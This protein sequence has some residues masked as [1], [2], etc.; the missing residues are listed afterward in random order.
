M[1]KY[2]EPMSKHCSLR[3]GGL[4]REFFSP[5]NATELSEFLSDNSKQVLFIGLGS[6]LLIRDH[7]FDGATIHT[8][9][10]KELAISGGIIDAE[11]GTTLAKL[12][13]FAQSNNKHGAEFLSAIPGSVGGALAMNA[14]AFGSEIWQY[15]VSVQT[16]NLSGKV[17]QRKKSDFVIDYRSVSHKH[18]DE[19]FLSARFDFNLKQQNDDV[20]DLL[21]KRNSTQPIGVPSCGS[22]FKNPNGNY[23]AELIEAS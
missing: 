18:I 4:T 5:K 21:E 20:R 17:H 19:F 12:S 7:G 6:N 10:L 11:S 2:N 22:V 13:R 23:A 9:H 8:K 16:I 1:L 3:S 14:G 15:V